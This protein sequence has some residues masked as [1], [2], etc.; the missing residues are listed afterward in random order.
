[1]HFSYYVY[2]SL[3][4]IKVIESRRILWSGHVTRIGEMGNTYK[5]SVWKHEGKRPLHYLSVDGV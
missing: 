2:S 4:I 1:M 5:T 3:N